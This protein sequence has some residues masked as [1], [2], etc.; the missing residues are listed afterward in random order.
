MEADV[1]LDVNRGE[2]RGTHHEAE[3]PLQVDVSDAAVSLE[4]P[5]HVLLPGRGGQAADEDT[6]S[7]HVAVGNVF[8]RPGHRRVSLR[9]GGGGGL[10]SKTQRGDGGK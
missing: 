5:L 9:G 4:E 6:T 10:P 2:L 8:Y 7:A 1:F 3:A